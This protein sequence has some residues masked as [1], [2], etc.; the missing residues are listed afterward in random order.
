MQLQNVVPGSGLG[1]MSMPVPTAAQLHGM[2]PTMFQNVASGHFH[3]VASSH[4][5]ENR[6]PR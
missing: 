1:P 2:A 6:L 5:Q 3:N 4:L